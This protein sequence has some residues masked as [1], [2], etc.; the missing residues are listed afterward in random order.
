MTTSDAP[1][2]DAASTSRRTVLAGA[3]VLGVAAVTGCGSGGGSS[4]TSAQ[5]LVAGK[6]G[7][8]LAKLD[9]IP[10][11]GAITATD[12]SGKPVVLSRPSAG[13]VRCFSGLCT[14]KGCAVKP[15]GKE[16]NCPCHQSNFDMMTGAV[17]TGPATKALP[18]VKVRVSGGEVVT[19]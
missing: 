14:H 11:G 10:V 5:G 2:Q 7:T 13:V 3:A 12:A 4:A 18:E 1:V 8:A 6:S 15:T 16:L 17:I 19:A 9:D